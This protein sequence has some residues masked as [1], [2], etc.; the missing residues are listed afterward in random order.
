MFAPPLVL[1]KLLGVTA[2]LFSLI[3]FALSCGVL[4]WEWGVDT[5]HPTLPLSPPLCPVSEMM[6]V[7]SS[8]ACGSA[9]RAGLLVQGFPGPSGS[10]GGCVSRPQAFLVLPPRGLCS[11]VACLSPTAAGPHRVRAPSAHL[12]APATL[13]RVVLTP[14]S[15]RSPHRAHQRSGNPG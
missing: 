7:R 8:R 9:G 6:D 15:Q 1:R 4:S 2:R 10:P 5:G 14:C 3:Q 12:Q 13:A 11:L